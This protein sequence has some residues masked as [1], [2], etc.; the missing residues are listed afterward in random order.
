MADTLLELRAMLP[1]LAPALERRRL[2]EALSQIAAVVRNAD[3]EIERLKAVLDLAR[4][5]AFPHQDLSDLLE[6]ALAAG[7][8]LAS[9][10]TSDE[11]RTASD[12]Y[13]DFLKT[14]PSVGMQVAR[15][16]KND[17]VAKN[18]RPLISFGVLL[19]KVENL[20]SLGR[21]MRECGEAAANTQ[22]VK[23]P[24]LRDEVMRLEEQLSRLQRERTERVGAIPA[25]GEFLIAVGNNTATLAL[26]TPA[27]LEWLDENGALQSFRVIS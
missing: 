13:K 20:A 11:L 4:L 21:E 22:M 26:L 2:G 17:V 5:I 14:L 3:A 12:A 10:T 6:A 23:W 1:S 15:H 8:A 16:W 24:E 7:Q 27:V 9:A 25:V 19:E 18:Y